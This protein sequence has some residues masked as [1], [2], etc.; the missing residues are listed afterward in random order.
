MLHRVQKAFLSALENNSYIDLHTHYK[1]L[2]GI[3]LM[4]VQIGFLP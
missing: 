3:L 2:F 4:S 1:E